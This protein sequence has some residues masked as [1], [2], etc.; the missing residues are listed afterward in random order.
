MISEQWDIV[1]PEDAPI[2]KILEPL[3][4]YNELIPNK[5]AA[6]SLDLN[7][8]QI[9]NSNF[10]SLKK[11]KITFSPYVELPG[12]LLRVARQSSNPRAIKIPGNL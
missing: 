8:F 3:V 5:M 6:E 11:V 4:K 9:R 12:F 1:V 7:G 10:L 2:Y